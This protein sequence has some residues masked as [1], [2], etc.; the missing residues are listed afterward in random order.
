YRYH[1]EAGVFEEL[2]TISALPNVFKGENLC[3]DIHISPDGKYLYASNRGH[4]SIVCFLI[5]QNTGRLTYVSHIP[6]EGLE[7]R[8]FAIDPS[9]TFLLVANQKSDNLIT[10]RID[11]ATGH[12][13]KT[14]HQIEV[15]MPVCMK[16]AY[17]NS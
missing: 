13:I 5:D 6:T 2:Q 4:D 7:P 9:G 16:F 11:K 12:L 3:A 15:P 14:G 10:F 17:L 8:N 1:S